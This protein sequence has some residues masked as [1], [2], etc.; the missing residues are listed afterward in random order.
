[1]TKGSGDRVIVEPGFIYS[2]LDS[3]AVPHFR[4]EFGN[5]LRKHN[6]LSPNGGDELVEIDINDLYSLENQAHQ[7]L[8]QLY[9]HNIAY[10]FL[11]MK[12]QLN[13][14]STP[15]FADVID[16]PYPD[17]VED[18]QAPFRNVHGYVQIKRDSHTAQLVEE[19]ISA[20][21][22][23]EEQIRT[24]NTD[25]EHGGLSEIQRQK[26]IAVLGTAQNMLLKADE[27]CLV[28]R[29]LIATIADWTRKRAQGAL[30][31]KVEN[32][33]VYLCGVA[34]TK[35]DDLIQVLRDLTPVL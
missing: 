11:R 25:P 14:G 21:E 35:L 15:V 33:F 32:T 3:R 5:F 18:R 4:T 16:P 23:L 27:G 12:D 28:D 1:M 20:L 31:S 13:R 7:E 30:N 6:L 34:T 26:L 2:G 17:V 10:E 24:Q 9:Y 8:G 29:G 19:A 22:R